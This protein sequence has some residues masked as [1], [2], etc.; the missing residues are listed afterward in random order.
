MTMK[1]IKNTLLIS[2][3]FI[4][5]SC[6]GCD[7]NHH[8]PTDHPCNFPDAQTENNLRAPWNYKIIDKTSSIN[9]V[10]TTADAVIH[11]D[12]VILMDENFNHI[13]SDYKYFIDNWIFYNLVPY[14][15]IPF[16]EPDEADVLLNLDERTFYLQTAYDDLDTIQVYFNQC[17]IEKVLFNGLSTEEPD[18]DPNVGVTSFYFRK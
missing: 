11:A 7:P 18:N 15:D 16:G 9:L 4:L 1:N 17:L 12:S 10:D 2:I 3:C 5:A 14:I 13:Y 8:R 6:I